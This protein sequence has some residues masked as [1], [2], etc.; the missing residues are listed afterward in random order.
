MTDSDGLFFRDG[1]D[2]E[3]VSCFSSL[4]SPRSFCVISDYGT[5]V[6]LPRALT[7]DRVSEGRPLVSDSRL[8]YL[9]TEILALVVEDIPQYSLASLALVNSDCRQLARS[10]Q[11]ASVLLDY[12]KH[13]WQLI[14]QLGRELIERVSGS[15]DGRTKKPAI[16]PCIRRITVIT[17]ARCMAE[18]HDTAHNVIYS[19]G[20]SKDERISRKK[21]ACKKY[22]GTYLSTIEHILLQQIALPHLNALDWKDPIPLQTCFF[23]AVSSSSIQHFKVFA[24][25]DRRTIICPPS[26]QTLGS[27]PLQTLYLDISPLYVEHHLDLSKFFA[28]LFR[29]CS[30]TL[31]SLTWFNRV[32]A[33]SIA[34]DKFGPTPVFPL[35]RQLRL[36]DI[37]FADAAIFHE[38][39]HDKLVSLEV[40]TRL[41][42]G[43]FDRRGRIPG[44]QTFVWSAFQPKDT[45]SQTFLQL[46][47][48]ISKLKLSYS[49]PASLL[50]DRILP[51][52]AESF[53]NLK[54]LSLVWD[55]KEK[56]ISVRALDL[57]SRLSTLEQ[58]HLSAG[59][60]D[61]R[62][63]N[64]H[65]DHDKMRHHLSKLPYLKKLAL[66]YDSYSNGIF[67]SCELYYTE[68]W[69]TLGDRDLR[70]D[71]AQF[72]KDHRD[73]M[74]QEAARYIEVMP[75][76]DWLYIGQIPMAIHREQR[77]EKNGEMV[78][79]LTSERVEPR[80]YL[81]E[82]FGW[83]GLLI[84]YA[85]KLFHS[86]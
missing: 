7:F 28:S 39:V 53:T 58:L 9:P 50:H 4:L 55:E 85:Y 38:L 8:L 22:Y 25:F 76:L 77:L 59:N 31:K 11:F 35:L 63:P 80:E 19:E 61:W 1:R 17:S 12:G 68:S 60:Q 82:M 40:D 45:E 33:P 81:T 86:R 34:F 54:S 78:E 64:W 84:P 79:P 15:K 57:I 24:R 62:R 10:R 72:E 83:P 36:E 65:I 47:S 14:Q 21:K 73:R 43:F 6:I 74:Q 48:H 32:A 67:G 71:H 44:L 27:W 26:S 18:F 41:A 56:D 51:L 29:L 66:S 70:S 69:P 13:S 75:S 3:D 16:G 2:P 5:K 23:N 30:P 37:H 20:F 46:N 49:T 42:Q 52:L